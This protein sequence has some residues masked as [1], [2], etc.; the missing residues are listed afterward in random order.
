M[1][2]ALD[3]HPQPVYFGTRLS[4]VVLIRK[5]GQVLFIERDIWELGPDKVPFQ[6]NPPTERRF[7]FT[8]DKNALRS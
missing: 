3:G 2:I 4:T 5:D 8:I 7:R 6:R 1:P